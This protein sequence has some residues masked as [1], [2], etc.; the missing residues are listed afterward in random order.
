MKNILTEKEFIPIWCENCNRQGGIF[1]DD[2]E[3]P[4]FVICKT[5]G[6]ETSQVWCPDCGM[7]GGFI[8][9]IGKRP[10][11]W[12]CPSCKASYQLPQGFYKKSVELIAVKDLR[13]D[14]RKKVLP[15][16]DT[17]NKIENAL[18]VLSTVVSVAGLIVSVILHFMF[19]VNGA[20]YK[21]IEPIAFIVVAT[22]LMLN[23]RRL[24]F[25]FRRF[26]WHGKIIPIAILCYGFWY[27]FTS[28]FGALNELPAKL[29]E[30]SIYHQ[31]VFMQSLMIA[32]YTFFC[33][34]WFYIN[35]EYAKSNA[36]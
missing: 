33:Y 24:S 16:R 21:E 29:R 14:V 25:Y 1:I 15:N 17:F 9:E 22:M 34:Y 7:G 11:S 36:T 6:W 28:P 4:C 12:N 20:R 18:R 5:C 35:Q 8:E 19:L 2:P 27:L 13:D 32:G 31:A 30:I 23:Y 26:S 3:E 10:K